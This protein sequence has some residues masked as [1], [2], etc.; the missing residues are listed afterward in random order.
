MGQGLMGGGCGSNLKYDNLGEGFHFKWNCQAPSALC[1]GEY[2][3]SKGEET[4][5]GARAWSDLLAH[6]LL[7]FWTMHA[8]VG[9]L[10]F[11]G[12]VQQNS[13][14]PSPV[15]SVERRR[16]GACGLRWTGVDTGD[17][18][19]CHCKGQAGVGRPL[20]ELLGQLRK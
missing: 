6:F 15:G 13:V 1:L 20:T 8:C 10:L 2:I 18:R 11:Q 19:L 4:S 9:V 7:F 5:L 16:M 3:F 14:L 17:A 12:F